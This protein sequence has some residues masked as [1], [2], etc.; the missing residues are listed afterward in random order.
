LV[1]PVTTLPSENTE[2]FTTGGLL[3]VTAGTPALC[4]TVNAAPVLTAV[5]FA[6]LAA[7]AL[8]T[9]LKVCGVGGVT[10]ASPPPPPQPA[11]ARLAS[12]PVPQ[13]NNECLILPVLIFKPVNDYVCLQPNVMSLVDVSATNTSQPC[14]SALSDLW[15]R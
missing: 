13:R 6:A 7:A 14:F 12:N 1:S 4:S 9:S 3:T 10:G 11:M 5:S 15:Y 2:N 8:M